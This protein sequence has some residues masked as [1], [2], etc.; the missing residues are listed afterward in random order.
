MSKVLIGS[1][2]SLFNLFFLKV[3]GKLWVSSINYATE[4]HL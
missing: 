2:N 1:Y 4:E 3:K